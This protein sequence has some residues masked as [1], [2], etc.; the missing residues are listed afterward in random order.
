MTREV[1]APKTGLR[2]SSFFS[3]LLKRPMFRA[4]Q[5]PATFSAAHP[6]RRRNSRPSI[7]GSSRRIYGPTSLAQQKYRPSG[8]RGV[9]QRTLRKEWVAS[10]TVESCGFKSGLL[11][12]RVQC[13]ATSVGSP[14]PL[15]D[16]NSGRL[17]CVSVPVFLPV[18]RDEIFNGASAVCVHR[19]GSGEFTALDD[20]FIE[21]EIG[22]G[23]CGSGR[24]RR[25]LG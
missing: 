15:R 18:P 3:E 24:H 22:D 8:H 6:G 20:R 14:C 21:K 4:V 5:H 13:V 10:C 11:G 23:G 17:L 2:P 19:H 16:G 25:S 12:H 9:V 7:S 1:Q